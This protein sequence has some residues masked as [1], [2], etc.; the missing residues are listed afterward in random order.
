MLMHFQRLAIAALVTL[1]LA[2]ASNQANAAAGLK[3]GCTVYEVGTEA[4]G[5]N[6][7]LTLHCTGDGNQYSAN[8]GGTCPTV[9]ADVVK[10]WQSAMM[11]GLLSGKQLN[12]AYDDACGSRAI[13]NVY[14]L[15]IP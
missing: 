13:T 8:W 11:S 15:S 2:T 10:T 12:V 14:L 1:I 5:T 6:L 7:K 3:Q 4:N 9:S